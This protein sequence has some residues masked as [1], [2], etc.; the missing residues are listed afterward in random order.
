MGK[1]ALLAGA[2]GLVGGYCLHRLLAHPAYDKVTVWSRRPL[3]IAHRKL[4]VELVD[5]DSLPVA[6]DACDE[7][8]CCLGT[9]I[10]VAGSKEAF[11]RVDHD[12]PLAMANHAKSSGAKAFLMVSSLGADPGSTVFYSRVKGETER[13]VMAVGIA[14]TIFLRPSILLGPRRERRPGERLGIFFGRLVS[15]LLA[16]PW[17]KYR[18]VH[19]DQ[20]AAAMIHA[21]NHDVSSGPVESDRIAELAKARDA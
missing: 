13:E 15:P 21:A 3:A 19:A 14:R 16:G 1:R 9:T 17:R 4:E 20:V 11:R 6:T 8:F 5:F 10:R 12:Y 2:S 7:A 18:P